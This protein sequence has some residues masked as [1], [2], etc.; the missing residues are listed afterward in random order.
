MKN[1][2]FASYGVGFT[3]PEAERMVTPVSAGP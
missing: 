3:T 1:G 2:W